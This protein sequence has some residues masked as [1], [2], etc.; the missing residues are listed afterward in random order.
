MACDTPKATVEKQI[1][2]VTVVLKFHEV[3]ELRKKSSKSLLMTLIM[4]KAM[5]YCSNM[6]FPR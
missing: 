6:L 4:K 1:H 3:A 5:K 2:S